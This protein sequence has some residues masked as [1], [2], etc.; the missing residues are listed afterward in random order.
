MLKIIGVFVCFFWYILSFSQIAYSYSAFVYDIKDGSILMAKDELVKIYPASITKIMTINL[1]IEAIKNQKIGIYDK[2]KISQNAQNQERTNAGLIQNEEISMKNLL[3]LTSMISAN[4]AACAVG[5]A[6]GNDSIANFTQMMNQK[7]NEL[8]MYGTNFTNATGLHNEDQ[9][10][11]TQDLAIMMKF[12][13]E[14]NTGYLGILNSGGLFF[15]GKNYQPKNPVGQN[16][17]CIRS[18][19]TGFT[20]KAGYNIIAYLSCKDYNIIANIINFQNPHQRDLYLSEILNY[21]VQKI[22]ELKHKD[23]KNFYLI[24]DK[25]SIASYGLY[26]ISSSIFFNFTLLEKDNTLDVIS[27]I[28]N[29][30]YNDYFENHFAYLVNSTMPFPKKP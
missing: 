25:L 7:S 20:S 24:E 30:I 23:S 26:L 22:G 4:D 1:A 12:F 8:K 11:T 27:G 19:K 10:S 3:L 16:Y 28:K 14:S 15:K 29:K 18:F 13:A 6:I 2:I 17:K 5:E 9:Y 21:A